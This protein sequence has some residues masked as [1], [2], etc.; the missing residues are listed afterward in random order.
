M[1]HE[2][3]TWVTNCPTWS[4]FLCIHHAH[5]QD[6][7]TSKKSTKKYH[8]KSVATVALHR[9]CSHKFSKVSLRLMIEH[10]SHCRADLWEQDT[11]TSRRGIPNL[12]WIEFLFQITSL[13]YAVAS[14]A[15]PTNASMYPY[16]LTS[17]KYFV[18]LT[19]FW[20]GDCCLNMLSEYPT[21]LGSGSTE[22]IFCT[23]NNILDVQTTIPCAAAR[24]LLSEY[25]KYC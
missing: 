9:H 24:R 11:K 16:S 23:A 10:H 5:M 7:Q 22:Q 6:T 21:L 13:T 25:P 15:L 3:N 2:W 14:R 19:I 1:G 17:S 18:L 4:L 8:K 12:F 20:T